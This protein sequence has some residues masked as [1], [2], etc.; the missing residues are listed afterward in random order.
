MIKTSEIGCSGWEEIYG[1]DRAV[2]FLKETLRRGEMPHALVFTGPR[3]VGKYSTA[4]LCAAALLCPAGEPDACACCLKVA[5]GVHP[6]LHL[7]EAE[8]NQ[9]LIDQVRDLEGE[10]SIKAKESLRKVAIVDEAGTMNQEAANAFLKTLEEPPP[11]T[12][13]ILVVESR[14]ALLETV[15]SRCHEVRFS[16]LGKRDIEA[17]LVERE[18][19]DATEAERL[20]RL[21][22]GIFGRALLWARYPDLAVNWNLGIELAASLR[23]SSL[24]S[25]LERA[26]D[27]RDRLEGASVHSEDKDLGVYIKAMDKRA[28]EQLRKRWEKREKREAV[29]MRRQAAL[30]LFDGMSSFYRDIMLLNLTEEQGKDA[31]EAPLLNREWIEELAREALHLGTGEAMRR[32]EALHAARKALEANVDIGLLLDSLVLELKGHGQ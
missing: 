20:A 30:D 2:G 9:I 18:G 15:A 8:G 19:L 13:I 1:Q 3:G 21:S 17:F 6:D 4:L 10:L 26:A 22:G 16:A 29:K 7:V 27:E 32:L 24:L 12:F 5:R 25:L 31:G 28:G 11:E 23:R 14:E